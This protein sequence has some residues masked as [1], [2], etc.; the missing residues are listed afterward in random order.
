MKKRMILAGVAVMLCM[1]CG[2][3]KDTP[4]TDEEM[5]IVAEYAAS[6]LLKYDNKYSTP[7][8]YENERA[9]RLTPTP[10][11]MPEAEPTKNPQQEVSDNTPSGTGGSKI[12][13]TPLPFD[14]EETTRQLTNLFAEENI[15]V[16]CKK[17]ELMRSVQS[18]EYFSLIAKEGRQYAVVSFTLHNNSNQ[19]VVFD[20]S[21]RGL[22]YTLDINAKTSFRVSLSM[23][24][25][26]LQYMEIPVPA[27]GTAD[28]VLV[29]EISAEEPDTIHLIIED[30]KMNAVFVKLK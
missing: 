17:Y 3:L 10:T 24:P 29:F 13:P 28:A 21:E 11:M 25:N 2:C 4:L 30:E 12:T 7:L 23:L 16:S 8:Y 20:A 27:N 19:D 9:E 6:L 15:T 14:H 5:D 26:D 1:M 22:E 18:T